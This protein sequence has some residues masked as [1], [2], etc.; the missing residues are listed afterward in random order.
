MGAFVE[1]YGEG[2]PVCLLSAVTR[3]AYDGDGVRVDAGGRSYSASN[4]LVTV[5]VGVLRAG[6][7]AFDPPLPEWKQRAIEELRMGHMQKVILPFAED[8]FPDAVPNS[9]VLVDDAVSPAEREL[10]T[11]EGLS[12]QRQERRV[13]AFVLQPLGADVAIGFFGGEWARLFEAQC[14]GQEHGS[15]PRSASGCDDLAIEAAV[16]A[17]SSVYGAEAV[18]GALLADEIHV[19]RWSLEPY[20]LGAYSVPAPGGWDQRE[21]LGQPLAAGAGGTEEAPRVFFAGEACSR[22]IY[23]GSYAGAFETGLAAAREIHAALLAEEAE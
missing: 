20:T 22:T 7:I 5:S 8:V 12:V 15:G 18:E 10:A 17:L 19:T 6:K 9:W 1:A 14:A 2:L 4:A 16:R 23:N 21:V 3:I 13:M 11:R